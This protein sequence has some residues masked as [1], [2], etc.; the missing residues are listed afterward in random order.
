MLCGCLPIG[1]R[2]FGIPDIIGNTGILFDTE[3]DL[4]LVKDFMLSELGEKESKR[5]RNRIIS[6]F[7]ISRRTE[8]IKE[9]ID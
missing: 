8:K 6:K 5:A 2:V 7:D 9:N 4:A 3:T 1:S